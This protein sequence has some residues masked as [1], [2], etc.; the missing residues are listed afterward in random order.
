MDESIKTKKN[1]EKY[2]ALITILIKGI[3]ADKILKIEN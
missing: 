2:T 3:A 1:G